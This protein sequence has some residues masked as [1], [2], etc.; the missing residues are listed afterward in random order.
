MLNKGARNERFLRPEEAPAEILKYLKV[1]AEVCNFIRL[2]NERSN[3]THFQT[4]LNRK[5]TGVV[6]VPAFFQEN[7]KAATKEATELAG[8]ELK[9]L[10]HEP[11]AAAIAYNEK[12]KL[13]NS[14]LL[15]FDF[16]GGQF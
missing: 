12:K 15:V 8:L 6:T 4:Y 5:V 10:L 16:G 13:G 14:K 9:R 7:Q 11:N 1:R 2:K 3:C